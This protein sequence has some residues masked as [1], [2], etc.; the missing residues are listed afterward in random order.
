MNIVV[1]SYIHQLDGK[2]ENINECKAGINSKNCYNELKKHIFQTKRSI[3][4]KEDQI[5]V[6]SRLNMI[7]GKHAV[8][9]LFNSDTLHNMIYTILILKKYKNVGVPYQFMISDKFINDKMIAINNNLYKTIGGKIISDLV[10][11]YLEHFFELLPYLMIWKNSSEY[12]IHKDLEFLIKK[13][14]KVPY[15]RF[16]IMKLTLVTTADTTH[17]NIILYDKVKNTLERFEPYGN[18]PY[19][20]SNLL[21]SFIEQIGKK[22]I[23]NQLTYFKPKDIIGDIG[24]QTISNDNNPDVKKLGDPVGFCLA[25]TIWYLEMR[26]NNPDIDPKTLISNIKE[27]ILN[28]DKSTSPNKLFIDFIRNYATGLDKQKNEFMKSAGINI[29]NIYNLVLS[30]KD[31]NR[32]VNKLKYEFNTLII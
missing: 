6:N 24:F 1:D 14:L 18:V 15:I 17:A 7:I 30:T 12:Y 22:Y 20:E 27:S 8:H 25:W 26:V 5:K 11:M 9:G 32:V 4:L 3:P 2:I 29:N 19:L 10:L 16:V 31:Q 28:K 21:D 23:N 13:T